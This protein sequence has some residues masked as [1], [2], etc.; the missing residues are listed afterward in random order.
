[1]RVQDF[2]RQG[3]TLADLQQRYAIKATRSLRY[4]QLVLLK[5]SQIDS[6]MAEPIVQEC[7]GLI[8]DESDNWCVV[9]RSYNKFFNSDEG[10]AAK[11][12]WATAQV[13]EKLDG[14]LCV[15]YNYRGEWLVQTSGHPDAA[16]KVN[17]QN[18]TFADL[19]WQTFREH[20]Y[21]PHGEP[22][23]CVAF[24]L[25]SKWNRVVVQH[26]V[27]SLTM[28]GV[29][30]R[31]TG[32]ES[33]VA[34]LAHVYNPVRSF[35]LQSLSD[36]SSTFQTMEPLKQEGYVVVDANFNRIKV[37]HPGYVAIHHLRDGHSTRRL[38]E[39]VQA[40][41]VGEFLAYFPEWREEFEQIQA[42]LA[43]LD[44][45]LTT[46]YD[47]IKHIVS[48][49]DFAHEAVKTRCSAALFL[50]RAGKVA[51]IAEYL[52]TKLR[53]DAVLQLLGMRNVE[54]LSE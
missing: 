33:S 11:V 27:A 34:S 54:A 13:Q 32:K 8:L 21:T 46:A 12:D 16:G 14:S 35:P 48:Q 37:K 36:I 4:P 38:V 49:K 6:P 43:A 39:I 45:E 17:D 53:P 22:N 20:G 50:L 3:N 47:K 15:L 9:S 2:L 18:F 51:S 31:R 29:R 41:E 19:F 52:R 10:H 40:G 23:V 1:M 30:C 5:Y 25:T 7:R 42:G 24:E 44:T 28:I 26:A